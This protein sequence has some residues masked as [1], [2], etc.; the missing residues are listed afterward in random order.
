[1]IGMARGIDE[2]DEDVGTDT[3]ADE[4]NEVGDDGTPP[5]DCVFAEKKEK[6]KGT[7]RK[8]SRGANA[9]GGAIVRENRTELEDN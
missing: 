7:F 9:S 5:P 6:K 3:P 1:M 4:C 8:E 2:G